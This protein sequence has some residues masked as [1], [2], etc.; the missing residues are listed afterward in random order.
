[1]EPPCRVRYRAPTMAAR[2]TVTV[3]EFRVLL[4]IEGARAGP[5]YASLL[6]RMDVGESAGLSEGDL[7]EMCLMSLQDREPD[8]AAAVVLAHDLGDELRPGQIAQMS[9]AMCDEKLWEEHADMELHE[10]LFHVGSLL[11]A[12][13]PAVFPEPDAVCV[14]VEVTPQN[15]DARA[16]LAAPL[17]ESFVVRLLAGGMEGGGLLRRLF[18]DQLDGAPF[19]EASS[20]AWIVTSEPMEGGGLRLQVTSSGHWLDP[21]RDTRSYEVSVRPDADDDED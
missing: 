6:D 11:H 15:A 9:H 19:P 1:M 21:L 4:E 18:E 3:L 20:I 14:T 8:E 10:R 16:V 2:F 13:F 7:R 5:D 17:P 12:A